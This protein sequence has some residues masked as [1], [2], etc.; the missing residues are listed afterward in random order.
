MA[1]LTK[2]R[3][4]FGFTSPRTIEKI[5]P[6]I[7]ILIDSFSGQ[8]WN[9]ETQIAFF[10]ELFKS[11]FYEGDKMPDN[12]SLAAR[13][14]ITRAPKALGFVDLKPKIAL[15]DVGKQLLSGK[16]ANE[17]ITRQLL[18]FQ[19]PSPYH[20]IPESRRFNI[21]PYLEL[22]RLVKELGNI[23]KTEIAIFFVQLTHYNKYNSVVA[24]IKKFR[25]D[26]S[27]QRGN[28]KS[29]I[30]KIFTDEILKIYYKEIKANDLK[31]RESADA[32]LTKFI[33]TKKSNHI[34]YADAFI[35]YL[36]ATQLISFEK[37]TFRMIVA[38]SRVAEVDF[39]LKNVE[40]KT[41]VFKTEAGF[42]KYLFS[43]T[44]LLLLTDD[45]KYLEKQL[46]KLSVK[47]DVYANVEVLKDLLEV[48]ENKMI[49]AVIQQAEVELKNYKEFDDIIEVFEKIQK[50]EI[51]D[52]PLYLEWNIWRAMVMINYAKRI[53]GNFRLDLDG[54]PLNTALGNLPDI[55]A[56]YDGFK[57]IFE[58]TMSSGNKQYEMEGEPV[59]RHFGK[60]QNNSA[61]P[62][63]C[64]F[65]APKISEGALAHF[66]NLNRMNTK[67]Y[68][69]KTRI[70]PMNLSQ[71]IL[72]ITIAKDKSFNNSEILKSYF[73][74]I[75]LKNLSLDD[76]TVWS[77]QIHD[78][79]PVWV[80]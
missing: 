35:R 2:T 54:V 27:E 78:S 51:P 46:S 52:P 18:K 68:G 26:I 12:I 71:F 37:K 48:T 9:T 20:K 25:T 61:V 38:P 62:V 19:L 6:E 74:S 40:R 10:H 5:I 33:R 17:V 21:K 65:V 7:Q 63:Y 4:V 14:R 22:L 42:K 45:R 50:K 31:T 73:D 72:F 60:V 15:S 29:F 11:E 47:F 24:A 58:V 36:R 79:I 44:S 43:P 30:D 13:D 59:A 3:T 76:E 70:V 56:E 8:K 49:S 67:A 66:F 16:R 39:V 53:T 55:E 1:N 75:I 80:S 69:G 34:D 64:L 41:K 77:Q 23:S 32:S 57:M 28:R